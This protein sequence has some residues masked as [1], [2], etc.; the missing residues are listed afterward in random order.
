MSS[1]ARSIRALL[2][3]ERVPS[4]TV[5]CILGMHRSGT[6]SLAGCLQ[7]AGLELGH[8][9]EWGPANLKGNRENRA[10]SGLNADVLTYSNGAWGRPPERLRWTRAHR[11]RRHDIIESF[12]GVP[13]WGFKDPRTVLTLSFW[14]EAIPE[15]SLVATYRHPADVASSLA[16]RDPIEVGKA[17]DLWRVYNE[18]LL[19]LHR[20]RPFPIVSFDLPAERYR[21]AVRRV[22]AELGLET[23][24]DGPTFFEAQLKHH[25]TVGYTDLPMEVLSVYRA[26]EEISEIGGPAS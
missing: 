23:S 12:D 1:I 25:S 14:R 3:R 20:Q 2:R 8:V 17:L 4:S 7:E 16:S 6:S 19:A 10:I 18:R 21:A 13:L 26:L 11:R 22:I 5:I 15:L 24:P 9:G